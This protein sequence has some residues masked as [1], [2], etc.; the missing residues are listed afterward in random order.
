M[1]INFSSS[2][3]YRRNVNEIRPKGNIDW[4]TNDE[5]DGKI[6]TYFIYY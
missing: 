6:K 2:Y 5:L 3:Y 1:I 4:D